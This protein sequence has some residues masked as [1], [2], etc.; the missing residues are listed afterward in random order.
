MRAPLF[1]DRPT[2]RQPR[3][4]PIRRVLVILAPTEA[5]VRSVRTL[6]RA[7]RPLGVAVEA[8]SECHGEV[9]G[10][11]REYLLP[12]LLLIDAIRRDWDAVVVAGGRGALRVAEDRLAREV[13]ALA[14]QRGK[15]IAALGIGRCLL[16]RGDVRGFVFDTGETLSRW[17]LDRLDLQNAGTWPT[18]RTLPVTRPGT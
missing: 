1:K 7:L 2:L 3:G 5:D 17:L 16:E 10:E 8:A 6:W 11:C 12:N 15:P 4:A 14:A 18:S 13:V 9:R